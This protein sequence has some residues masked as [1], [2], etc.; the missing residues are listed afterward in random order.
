MQFKADS[1]L[2]Y[3]N[4]MK[5]TFVLCVIRTFENHVPFKEHW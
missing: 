1:M 3:M 4:N 5:K 2:L